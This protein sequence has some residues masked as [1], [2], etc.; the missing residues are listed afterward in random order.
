[1]FKQHTLN[2]G[3]R[4][5]PY[6]F[7]LPNFSI[8]IIFVVIPALYGLYYSFTKYDGLNA[9][10]FIG[11]ANYIE[12]FGD[13]KFW[14]IF[15]Q[16]AYYSGIVVPGIFIF[17]LLVALMLVQNIR[18]KSFFRAIIYWPTMISFIVVGVTWK[19][20]FGDTFGIFNYLIELSGN[21]P[22]PWLTDP[23]FAKLTIIIA[24][25]WGRVGFYMVIFMAGLQNIPEQY[26]EAAKIDGAGKVQRFFRITIPLLKPTSL[27]VLMLSLIE[28]F[29][30][31]PLIVALT[32]GGPGNSTTY[33]VQYIYRYGFE[34][35][36]LGY[37]SAMSVILFLVIMI[38]TALQFRTK[39]D[40]A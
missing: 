19:W 7:L 11:F 2:R 25:L 35:S 31:Y 6:L 22:V 8:F 36:E 26:Y 32:G 27:M 39:G 30:A 17:S 1:M 13:Q 5:A 38:L 15:T 9:P 4:Y 23:F 40:V 24:T 18:F 16:T 33:L 37:A 29:K 12:I 10:E 34:K 28:S 20:I 21:L 14:K 3:K